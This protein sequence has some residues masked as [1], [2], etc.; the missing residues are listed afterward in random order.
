M[1]SDNRGTTVN[2]TDWSNHYMC[3]VLK[4]SAIVFLANEDSTSHPS[5]SDYNHLCD[6]F[7]ETLLM[8]LEAPTYTTGSNTA[9]KLHNK[10]PA[11]TPAMPPL[12]VVPQRCPIGGFSSKSARRVP[13][14]KPF[15]KVFFPVY[16]KSTPVAINILDSSVRRDRSLDITRTVAMTGKIPRTKQHPTAIN[17]PPSLGSVTL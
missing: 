12:A 14:T 8:S 7:G 1:S 3:F 4:D 10:E 6:L 15:G 9:K 11:E 5:L 2:V 17:E 16:K 13:V